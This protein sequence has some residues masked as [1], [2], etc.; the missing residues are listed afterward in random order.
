M[1]S[2]RQ[3]R[4]PP[5]SAADRLPSHSGVEPAPDSIRAG[6]HRAAVRAATPG[7]LRRPRNGRLHWL[8]ASPPSHAVPSTVTPSFQRGPKSSVLLSGL[9]LSVGRRALFPCGKPETAGLGGWFGS[10]RGCR[11]IRV[12]ARSLG[13]D[14]RGFVRVRAR[15]AWRGR[16]RRGVRPPVRVGSASQVGFSLGVGLAGRTRAPGRGGRPVDRLLSLPTLPSFLARREH[17]CRPVVRGCR[18][19]RGV[20]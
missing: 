19:R 12:G 13:S 3:P 1:S 14:V 20:G 16:G 5:S 15:A 11:V 4:R 18:C 17:G 7:A 6:I 2:T 9:P 8:P 10:V